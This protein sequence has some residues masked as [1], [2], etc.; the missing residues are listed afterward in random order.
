MTPSG[1]ETLTAVWCSIDASST[2]G[3][4]LLSPT[5]TA[6]T[7]EAVNEVAARQGGERAEFTWGGT[8]ENSYKGYGTTNYLLIP[9][10]Q[11]TTAFY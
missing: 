11:N 4:W 10:L 2:G 1:Q 3:D 7:T 6:C 9:S 8:L 5:S